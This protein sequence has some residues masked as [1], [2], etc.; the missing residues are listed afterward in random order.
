[1]ELNPCPGY[2]FMEV[3]IALSSVL[4]TRLELHNSLNGLQLK[5]RYILQGKLSLQCSSLW[6]SQK[7]IEM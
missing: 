7:P 3:G 1:M 5:I 4:G 2:L 6:A